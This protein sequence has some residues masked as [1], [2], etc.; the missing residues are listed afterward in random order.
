MHLKL[1]YF[2]VTAALFVAITICFERTAY[3]YVDPGSSILIYQGISATVAG[4][5]FHFRRRLKALFT[6]EPVDP[7]EPGK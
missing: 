1:K 5:L 3:A 2:V 6:R 4:A 7:G